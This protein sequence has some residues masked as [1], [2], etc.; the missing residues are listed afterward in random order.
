RCPPTK[1]CARLAAAAEH[2]LLS[3]RR[4]EHLQRYLLD[5]NQATIRQ[6][7]WLLLELHPTGPVDLLTTL[8]AD[9][10][11]SD[12]LHELAAHDDAK[13]SADI[14]RHVGACA[15]EAMA[16][17][18][19][20]LPILLN[21]WYP[22][23]DHARSLIDLLAAID[24]RGRGVVINLLFQS[25]PP[26]VAASVLLRLQPADVTQLD[27]MRLRR[28]YDDVYEL[29]DRLE[30]VDPARAAAWRGPITPDPSP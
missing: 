8:R 12:V 10:S 9:E 23:P 29:L 21:E 17:V 6:R 3:P 26:D 1:G 13:R 19:F 5:A 16:N 25:H 20:E 2:D 24:G 28:R 7:V 4:R 14:A 27:R 30:Q 22:L 11:S 18:L 15:P